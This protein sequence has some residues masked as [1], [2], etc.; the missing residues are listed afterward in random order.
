MERD[1]MN[2][3]VKN[4]WIRTREERGLIGLRKNVA[5]FMTWMDRLFDSMLTLRAISWFS[6]GQSNSVKPFALP[7]GVD[8]RV[9][10]D[11]ILPHFIYV[12]WPK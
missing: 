11:I 9:L 12:L 1:V 7:I 10:P 5:L 3:S 4:V 8:D 2:A 6:Q